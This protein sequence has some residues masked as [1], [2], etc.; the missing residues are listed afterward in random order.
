MKSVK[1][2]YFRNSERQVIK[3][4]IVNHLFQWPF[5]MYVPG[6][7]LSICHKSNANGA[8]GHC[9]RLKLTSVANHVGIALRILTPLHL[10]FD[11]PRKGFVYYRLRWKLV[12]ILH[13]FVISIYCHARILSQKFR[14]FN[15]TKKN[16]CSKM[17][18]RIKLCNTSQCNVKKGYLLSHEKYFVK[19]DFSI[20]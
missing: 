8:K 4:K 1:V 9:E 13:V 11:W 10:I 18:W 3:G 12:R 16:C 6:Y 7:Y 5:H 2:N 19:T 17:I 14:Q 20:K 15:F